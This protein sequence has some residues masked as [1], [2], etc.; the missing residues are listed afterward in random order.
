[1]YMFHRAVGHDDLCRIRVFHR[2]IEG[3][4]QRSRIE[5][6]QKISIQHLPVC[7]YVGA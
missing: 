3:I 6:G 1:M 2:V 5:D 4:V 7:R